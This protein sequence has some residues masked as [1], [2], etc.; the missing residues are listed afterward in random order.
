VSLKFYDVKTLFVK[1]ISSM[2]IDHSRIF[3]A[4]IV[5]L[6]LIEQISE[7]QPRVMNENMNK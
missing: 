7:K 6:Q 1:T 5:F 3:V 4:E 2:A